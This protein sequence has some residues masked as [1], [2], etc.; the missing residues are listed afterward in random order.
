MS[1]FGSD[2]VA[3]DTRV[4]ETVA[5]GVTLER[6]SLLRLSA[7]TLASA[8]ALTACASSPT[9]RSERAD[10]P[11]SD[12]A[13]EIGELLSELRPD[14]RRV[15]ESG[16]RQEE[17]YL[18]RVSELLAR[19]HVPTQAELRAAM[20]PHP[21]SEGGAGLEIWLAMFQ[22]EAGKGF[23]HHDHRDY[24]G[25]IL[26]VEGEARVKNFDILGDDLVPPDGQTFQIRQT[27]DD[28]I[29]PGRFS[30][31]GRTREN[32]HDLVAGP[33]GATVIDAFTYFTPEARSYFMDVD[34]VPRDADRRIYDAVWS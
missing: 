10:E 22:L 25:V 21:M 7:A 2:A 11:L 29:L 8:F 19:L 17:A 23:T 26:G 3:I 27:R 4:N 28:V 12:G 30:S 18:A 1:W 13:L 32:V 5:E 15:V 14:A 6:R 20:G 16:G 33:G 24:N 9:K 34:P 31:L